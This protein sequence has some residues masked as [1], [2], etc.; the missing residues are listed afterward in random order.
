LNTSDP[1]EDLVR[2]INF[3]GFGFL[4]AYFLCF[5]FL[6]T[7][8][9]PVFFL[10]LLFSSF[11]CFFR[12]LSVLP[13]AYFS[14]DLPIAPPAKQNNPTKLYDSTKFQGGQA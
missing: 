7:L 3:F 9:L 14:A 8:F 5:L 11:G 4:P 12:C 6:F 1:F 10:A 13:S 2:P